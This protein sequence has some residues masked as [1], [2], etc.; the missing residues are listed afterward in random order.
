MLAERRSHL[1]A[2][3]GSTADEP[4]ILERRMPIDEKVAVAGRLVL[5]DPGFDQRRV[6]ERGKSLAQDA[7]RPSEALGAR[8]AVEGCRL[9][10]RTRAV[11]GDLEAATLVP[12]HSVDDAIAHVHPRGERAAIVLR[13]PRGGGKEEDFL[14]R[15]DD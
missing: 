13:T 1:E 7:S 10:L 14:A 9:D 12:R 4:D 11:V 15:R 5:A 3:S 8:H 2:V 6:P